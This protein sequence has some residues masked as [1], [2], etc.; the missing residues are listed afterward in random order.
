MEGK[1]ESLREL[2]QRM[3]AKGLAPEL[4]RSIIDLPPEEL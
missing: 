3:Q 1:M 4:I 2:A